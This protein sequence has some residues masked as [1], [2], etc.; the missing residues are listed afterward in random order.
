MNN[1]TKFEIETIILVLEKEV[2]QLKVL[3]EKH[4]KLNRKILA[5]LYQEDVIAINKMIDNLN[6]PK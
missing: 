2:K 3:I 6:Q 5:N 4:T 1:L